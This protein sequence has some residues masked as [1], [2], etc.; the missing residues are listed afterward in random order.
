MEE[1]CGSVSPEVQMKKMVSLWWD[2]QELEKNQSL[3]QPGGRF[4]DEKKDGLT[5]YWCYEIRKFLNSNFE[6]KNNEGIVINFKIKNLDKARKRFLINELG[7]EINVKHF[8]E[9]FDK[10]F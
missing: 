6:Y 2:E 10:F 9:L 7:K 5:N 4:Y 3:F 1:K 8:L